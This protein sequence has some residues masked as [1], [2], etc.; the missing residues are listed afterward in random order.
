[1]A[2]T[3]IIKCDVCGEEK[4]QTN[5]PD[6]KFLPSGEPVSACKDCGKK[7]DKLNAPK[8][9]KQDEEDERAAKAMAERLAAEKEKEA[10][11][12]KEHLQGISEMAQSIAMLAQGLVTIAQQN[13]QIL[14]RLS[15]PQ[16]MITPI[17]IQPE[18]AADEQPKEK[19]ARKSRAKR[20]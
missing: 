3:Y 13:Q 18:P 4:R 19:P 17:P 6:T 15:G 5:E 9:K 20:G 14:N 8:K 10:N 11:K 16:D 1:M 7:I 2:I 12:G